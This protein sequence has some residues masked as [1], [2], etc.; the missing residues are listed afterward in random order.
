MEPISLSIKRLESDDASI[1]DVFPKIFGLIRTYESKLNHAASAKKE[2][3]VLIL[4][5]LVDRCPLFD[6]DPF[7]LALFFNQPYRKIAILVKYPEERIK[8]KL[9]ALLRK[10]DFKKPFVDEVMQQFKLYINCIEPYN[11]NHPTYR[12]FWEKVPHNSLTVLVKR[13]I[14][15][16]PH[17]ARCERLFSIMSYMKKKWQN[18]MQSTT[19]T[20]YTQIKLRYHKQKLRRK[21]ATTPARASLNFVDLTDG[22]MRMAILEWMRMNLQSLSKNSIN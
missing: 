4:R 15:I 18:Q 19:L 6:E 2:A 11:V 12:S 5:A 3:Y 22:L 17:S 7:I 8:A 10:W 20:A 9:L 21:N 1:M 13:L 16:L 14:S